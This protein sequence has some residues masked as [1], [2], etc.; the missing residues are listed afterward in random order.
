MRH[1]DHLIATVAR[2]VAGVTGL[3]AGALLLLSIPDLVRY[4]KLTRM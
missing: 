3:A 2:V 4:L 1:H